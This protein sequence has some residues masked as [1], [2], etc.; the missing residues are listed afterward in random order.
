MDQKVKGNVIG[1]SQR[2]ESITSED[3]AEEDTDMMDGN[4]KK[5]GYFDRLIGR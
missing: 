4:H 3:A 5:K 2:Q 1:Q